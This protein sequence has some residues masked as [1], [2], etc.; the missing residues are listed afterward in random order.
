MI[1]PTG[2]RPAF[3]GEAGAIPKPL[4]KGAALNHPASIGILSYERISD[5]FSGEKYYLD[6]VYDW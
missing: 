1:I 3:A 6:V 5:K 4:V 2:L